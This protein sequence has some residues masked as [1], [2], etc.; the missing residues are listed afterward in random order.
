[1]G[2]VLWDTLYVKPVFNVITNT[3]TTFY[4]QRIREE[5]LYKVKKQIQKTYKIPH[6]I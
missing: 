4:L 5:F 3:K 2:K 6:K 1:M